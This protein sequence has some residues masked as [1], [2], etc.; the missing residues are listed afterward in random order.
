MFDFLTKKKVSDVTLARVFING[1]LQTVDEGFE[2]VKSLIISD[3]TFTQP[4]KIE[5]ATDDQFTMILI[6]GNLAYLDH[7]FEPNKSVIIR[8]SVLE[9][10]ATVFEMSKSNLET[11]IKNYES[12]LSRVNHPSKN[13]LYAISKAIFFKYDL[14]QYQ[15]EYFKSLKTPSPVFIKHLNQAM[16]NFIWDWSVVLKNKKLQLS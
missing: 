11:L 10:L 13:T 4:P 12:Y 15:D 1:L 6:A 8:D 9:E 2:E 7:F 3:P 5:S 16:E 14:N